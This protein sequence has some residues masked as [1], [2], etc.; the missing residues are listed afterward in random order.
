MLCKKCGKELPDDS[1]FCAFCGTTIGAEVEP[2]EKKTTNGFP[3]T[4]AEKSTEKKKPPTW[5]GCLIIIIV[6]AI[7]GGIIGV[8]TGGADNLLKA[9]IFVVDGVQ[10]EIHN[11]DSYDWTDVKLILNSSY[12]LTTDRMDA[13][14]IYTVGM[15]QFTKGDGTRFNPFTQTP[16]KL[17]IICD[18]GSC[19]YSWR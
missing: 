12:T 5:V 4:P 3:Q 16:L 1:K 13:N 17:D 15:G 10:L 19:S 7:I 11:N 2:V 6:L 18:K 9:Q 8:C 14:T